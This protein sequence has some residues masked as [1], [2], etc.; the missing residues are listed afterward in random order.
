MSA[1]VFLA[2]RLLRCNWHFWVVR[3][4]AG[5][6]FLSPLGKPRLPTTPG[7]DQ[8]MLRPP[9]ITGEG[10]PED[11]PLW[12]GIVCAAQQRTKGPCKSQILCQLLFLKK[13]QS[14]YP[15]L[16]QPSRRASSSQTPSPASR[17]PSSTFVSAPLSSAVALTSL[18]SCPTPRLR[19]G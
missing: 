4:S 14:K 10:R 19:R 2:F 3:V 17:C 9:S 12:V 16:Y 13:D 6:P 11:L 15:P 1:P 18:A 5:V 7:A 8:W